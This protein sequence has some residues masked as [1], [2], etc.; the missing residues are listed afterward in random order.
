[1]GAAIWVKRRIARINREKLSK[2]SKNEVKTLENKYLPKLEEY[3]KQLETLGERNSY[4]KTDKDAT[5]MRMK[6]DHMKNG[7]L[8]PA[9][10]LQIST[11]NQFF[12]HCNMYPNPGDTL[13]FIPFMKDFEKRYKKHPKKAVAD[14]GYGSLEN[15]DYMEA[16]A[17]EPF[18]KFNYFHREQKKMPLSLKICI[19]TRKRTILYVLWDKR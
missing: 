9:Y 8:K 10:N 16:I 13:T 2:E 15:Y 6:E 12:T 7:Q 17:I 19:I 4:S 3:E 14:A 5:F 1:V 11:E 18:V